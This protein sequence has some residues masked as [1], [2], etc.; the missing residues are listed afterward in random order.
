MTL[1]SHATILT[2]SYP[3]GHGV[4]SNGVFT[5]ADHRHTMAEMLGAAGYR[6]GAF[7][8]AFVLDRRFGLN[9]GFETYDDQIPERDPLARFGYMAERRADETCGR[10]IRWL[11]QGQSE[12]GRASRPF[13]AWLHLFD[14]HQDYLPPE[15]F[16]GHFKGDLYDGEIAFTDREVGRV[17]AELRRL[18]LDRKRAGRKSPA[19]ASRTKG[20]S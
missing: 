12:N 13:F 8:S 18:G 10:L 1:P 3:P 5:L 4:R 6:T 19:T 15:P 7:V 16:H 11:E 20:N 14:P 2:G 9:Q 17:L